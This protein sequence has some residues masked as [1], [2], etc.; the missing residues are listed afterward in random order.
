MYYRNFFH[1]PLY[2]GEPRQTM[3]LLC[4]ETRMMMKIQ[5]N[6]ALLHMKSRRFGKTMCFWIS[7]VFPPE[8]TTHHSCKYTTSEKPTS[9][10]FSSFRVFFYNS[11]RVRKDG[12]LAQFS[13][14]CIFENRLFNNE[15]MDFSVAVEWWY[16]L[17]SVLFLLFRECLLAPHCFVEAKHT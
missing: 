17:W 14:P 11:S 13:K 15:S 12:Y 1:K 9:L 16:F 10:V 3:V 8:S 2:S 5:I 4:L 6:R 7:F